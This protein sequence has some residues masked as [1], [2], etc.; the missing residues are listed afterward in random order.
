MQAKNRRGKSNSRRT[1]LIMT[2]ARQARLREGQFAAFLKTRVLSPPL[3]PR[4]PLPPP[5]PPPAPPR[6]APPPIETVRF[7]SPESETAPLYSNVNWLPLN[8]RITLN[9]TLLPSMAPSEISTAAPRPPSNEPVNSL[10]DAFSTRV[11]VTVPRRPSASA[12]HLPSIFAASAA[13]EIP[14]S[15]TAG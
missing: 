10:P 13:P 6:R 12:V 2:H 14:S 1:N 5:K 15:K 7:K 9:D 3:P 11:W 4:P 8:S